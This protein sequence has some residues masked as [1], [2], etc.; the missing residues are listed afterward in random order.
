MSKNSLNAY[1]TGGSG[2]IGG[3]LCEVLLSQFNAN[4]TVLAHRMSPGLLRVARNQCNVSFTS[5]LDTQGLASDLEDQDVVFHLAFGKF[6]DGSERRAI[7]VEG[8][9][10]LVE[11]ALEKK[12]GFFVYVSTAAVYYHPNVGRVDERSP[13]SAWGWDYVDEKLE[14]ENIVR[15][16]IQNRGLNGVIVQVAGVYG[17]WGENFTINPLRQMASGKI[18]LPDFG[19]GITN[20]TY[21]DDTVQLLI[22]ALQK[23]AIGETFIAKGTGSH[24]R[25]EFFS[26]YESLFD[27]S[28][29][30]LKSLEDVAARGTARNNWVSVLSLP[31]KAI[32][33]LAGS[34]DFRSAV[35]ATPLGPLAKKF[36]SLRSSDVVS[37]DQTDTQSELILHY[38]DP[39]V[40]DYLACK[41]DLSSSKAEKM[42][43]FKSRY[44]LEE[45]MS[46]TKDWATWARLAPRQ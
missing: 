14:G 7:T 4:V 36:R 27:D 38:P 23:N 6:G 46:L 25:A 40:A 39:T 37:S 12:V 30:E 31:K 34:S 45:G 29:L 21:I 13:S 15:D 32:Q 28:R 43:G 17:P 18:V 41:M 22:L 3:R 26:H 44:S 16:A 33:T 9:R 10:A 1:L 8:T 2:F 35:T 42:L 11:A 24:T 20:A 5:L 19:K